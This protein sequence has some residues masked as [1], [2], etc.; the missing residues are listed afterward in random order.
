[1]LHIL[2]AALIV[3][4]ADVERQGAAL[5]AVVNQILCGVEVALGEP[6]LLEH[7]AP[8]AGARGEM[9]S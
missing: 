9:Q 1:L 4:A 7:V 3:L 2:E 6:V 8:A 5:A